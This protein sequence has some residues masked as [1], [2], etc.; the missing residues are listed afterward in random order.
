MADE[1]RITHSGTSLSAAR[2]KKAR[3]GVHARPSKNTMAPEELKD[4]AEQVISKVAASDGFSVMSDLHRPWWR[5]LFHFISLFNGCNK[6][7][8]KGLQIA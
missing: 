7:M 3:T 8:L 1:I 5:V 4:G 6:N 2:G